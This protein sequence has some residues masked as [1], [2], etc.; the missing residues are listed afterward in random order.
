MAVQKKSTELK[1][2]F[3]RKRI[4]P[5]KT[6]WLISR[7]AVKLWE[8]SKFLTITKYPSKYWLNS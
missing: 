7:G 5:L 2:H 6:V 1:K 4:E 3:F 8:T